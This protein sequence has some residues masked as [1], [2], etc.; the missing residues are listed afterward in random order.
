VAGTVATYD[1]TVSNEGPSDAL[2]VQLASAVLP[3]SKSS[4]ALLAGTDVAYTMNVVNN[5]LSTRFETSYTFSIDRAQQED[6][7]PEQ[8]CHLNFKLSFRRKCG[9]AWTFM[10]ARSSR[11]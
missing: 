10:W 2:N 8:E 4:T 6:R 9:R 7:W 1:I 3:I 11:S 5:I